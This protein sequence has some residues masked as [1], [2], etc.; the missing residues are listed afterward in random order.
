MA[1]A[2]L[3]H[4]CGCMGFGASLSLFMVAQFSRSTM[5]EVDMMMGDWIVRM[6]FI[7]M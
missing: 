1:S 6:Y 5:K 2:A 4:D 7:V 3:N